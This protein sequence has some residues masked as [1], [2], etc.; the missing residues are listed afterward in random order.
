MFNRRFRC[1]YT[2]L[3][4]WLKKS[5]VW[6][7]TLHFIGDLWIVFCAKWLNTSRCGNGPF[8]YMTDWTE[9]CR[10]SEAEFTLLLSKGC[11]WKCMIQNTQFW[12][13]CALHC[14]S[15]MGTFSL[16]Y[17]T[18]WAELDTFAVNDILYLIFIF[19]PAEPHL[20]CCCPV[21]YR[22]CIEWYSFEHFLF[23]QIINTYPGD[24]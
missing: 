14:A 21:H 11:P 1:H 24:Y 17:D 6:V 2:H 12:T 20:N 7:C 3:L 16:I 8:R 18:S 15:S 23:H 5:S 19:C 4:A 9:L 13:R 22:S 10:Y